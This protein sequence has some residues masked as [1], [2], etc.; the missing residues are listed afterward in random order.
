MIEFNTDPD[1]APEKIQAAIDH[2][3]KRKA[4][5]AASIV[6][7][8]YG[9][10]QVIRLGGNIVLTRLLIPE[11]FGLITTARVFFLG[12]GLFT[13]IGLAPAIIRSDRCGDPKFINTAWTIQVVRSFVLAALA[14][15][16]AWPVAQFAREPRLLWIIPIIGLI[17]IPD[18]FRSTSLVM[19]SKDLNQRMLIMIEIVIQVCSLTVMIILAYFFRNVWALLISDLVGTLVRTLWSHAINKDVPDRFAF[20]KKT[21][22]ELLSFGKWILFSTAVMFLASQIDRLLLGRLFSMAWLGV[23]S[24]AFNLA[25][26]P[27]KIMDRLTSKV[28]YPLTTKYT[29]LSRAELKAK[30]MAPRKK[31]LAF[32]AFALAVS[33][34]FGDIL[35]YILY[36]TRYQDA[37]WILPLLAFGI[38][39]RLLAA[40]VEGTLLAIGKPKYGAYSNLGKFLFLAVAIPLSNIFYKEVGV[41]VSLA[42]SEI[43]A[44]AITV[45][46][47]KKEKLSF[48]KQDSVFTLLLLVLVAAFMAIRLIVGIGLPGQFRFF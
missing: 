6:I 1:D 33:G 11:I 8:G 20:D 25:D 14:C 34:S 12:I 42:I 27:K 18:G 36:D 7:F 24:I 48:L 39:P 40:T 38:W 41:I 37:A 4:V 28:I 16:I 43:P 2:G 45:V 19:L 31:L 13:D 17:S 32:I 15:L 9:L 47:L 10:S 30:I 46:G 23:Y 21:A 29:H 35:V 26:V 44:Y 5:H 3:N 22:R